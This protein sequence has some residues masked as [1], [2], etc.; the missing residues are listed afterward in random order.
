MMETIL[1]LGLNDAAAAALAEETGDARFAY[2]SY[3]RLLQMFGDVVAGVASHV[4]EDALTRRKAEHGAKLD[5]DLTGDDLR[6]LCTEFKRLYREGCGHD[7]PQDPREQLRLAISAVFR[8]WGAPR[9]NVYR[10]AHDISDDLGTA[11]NICQ[12]VFGNRGESSRH[13]RLLHPRPLDR[14]ARAV[15]RVPAER[16]GRGRRRRHPHAGADRAHARAAARGLRRARRH[17]RAAR[18]PPPRG[19]GHRV[20]GRAGQALHAPDAHRQAHRRRGA[21]DRA[22]VRRGGRDHAGRGRHAHR[23]AQLEHLLHP[24][25]DAS[26]RP[27]RSRAGSAH[28]RAQRSAQPSSTP[29]LRPRR[30]RPARPSCS[31]AGRRRPTTS[32]A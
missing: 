11:A 10:R 14:R 26:A 13:R 19:A 9:A 6:G 32:T 12:M 25:L 18:A 17:G 8:S 15:R 3:R 1:N 30:A 5:T 20:H 7:F 27:S 23:S 4:F 28:R 29:T 22:R 16:P 31:C 2:D 24:R 21:A